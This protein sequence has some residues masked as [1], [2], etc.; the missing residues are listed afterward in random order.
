M[1]TSFNRV[2]ELPGGRAI[3]NG[4][5]CLVVAE[6]SGNHNG[7]F[8]R[9]AELV[10]KAKEAGA[11]AVKLQTYTA[12]TLTINSNQPCFRIA[13]DNP[14]KGRTLYELYQEAS[15]PW[16]WHEDLFKLG[17]ELGLVVFS[18][19]F[20][21][22]A[23]DFLEK[24]GSPLH[25]IASFELVD[26]ELVR[27]VAATGKP[28]VVSTGMASEKEV[29]E[30]VEAIASAGDRNLVLLKCTSAYPAPLDE[31]NL[32]A[33][34]RLRERF[35]APAGLSDHSLG[36]RAAVTAVALGACLIEKHITLDRAEGG[37]DASFSMNPVEFAAMVRAIRET[38]RALGSG[39]FGPGVTESGS[40]SFRRSIFAVKDIRAGETLTREN[41]RVIRPGHGLAPRHLPEVLR[42][43]AAVDIAR[44]TPI[45]WHMVKND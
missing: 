30:A 4:R 3:G 1:T 23:V 32:R 28:V 20:D 39:V 12:D 14:W 27:R 40:I 42:R 18:T 9:A 45:A 2:V 37:V 43:R 41:I 34:P 13:G 24:L 33:I 29:A 17:R 36:D 15:T 44:G 11:D 31:M 35:G 19:P 25:K 8:D 26:L 10:R 21:S 7:R 5:P 38:E 6:L 16:E 22:T